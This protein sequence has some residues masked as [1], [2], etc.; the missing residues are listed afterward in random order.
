MKLF[1]SAFIIFA[2]LGLLMVGAYG[3]I[4]DSGSIFGYTYADDDYEN[5]DLVIKEGPSWDGEFSNDGISGTWVLNNMKPG[6]FTDDTSINLKN[7]G[8]EADHLDI[9]FSYEI[10]EGISVESETNAINS[11]D[12]MAREMVIMQM[13]YRD[14]YE[15]TKIDL[16]DNSGPYLKD[17]TED[18]DENED[19]KVSLYEFKARGGLTGLPATGEKQFNMQIMFDPGAG[20]DFQ[21]DTLEMNLT[22]SLVQDCCCDGKKKDKK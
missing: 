11:A 17:Q 18:L 2:A 12:D 4:Y 9:T 10:Y 3:F 5:P 16:L 8:S 15:I 6:Y 1:A 21:G 14:R 22:F 7:N 19:G 20:N 13:Y